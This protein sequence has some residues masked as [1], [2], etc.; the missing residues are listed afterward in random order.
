MDMPIDDKP[1]GTDLILRTTLEELI[2]WRGRAIA[3]AHEA[4]D[5]HVLTLEKI[6]EAQKAYAAE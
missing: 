3:L 2:G 1:A 5:M 4:R 6:K